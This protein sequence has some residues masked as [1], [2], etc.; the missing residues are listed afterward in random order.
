MR[1]IQGH[2]LWNNIVKFGKSK[3][4]ERQ[5]G[6]VCLILTPL[7]EKLLHSKFQVNDGADLGSYQQ[8]ECIRS[9]YIMLFEKYGLIFNIYAYSI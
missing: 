8:L 6:I 3:P 7:K 5:N 2:V 9:L 4:A 1:S